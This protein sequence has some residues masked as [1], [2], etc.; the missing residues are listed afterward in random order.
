MTFK[1]IGWV[2]TK[3][4]KTQ[5]KGVDISNTQK[6]IRKKKQRERR[7]N[8]ERVSLNGRVQGAISGVW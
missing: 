5:E 2:Y 3:K 4:V 6:S 8:S 1:A 7:E